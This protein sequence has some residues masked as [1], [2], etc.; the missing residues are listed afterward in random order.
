M[1]KNGGFPPIILCESKELEH[2]SDKSNLP[3]KERFFSNTS[4]NN[5]N[6]RQILVSK[7][8]TEPLIIIDEK[9]EDELEVID[10]I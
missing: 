7:Q 5:I 2:S 1:T 10:E 6:I 8:K 3:K 9:K 4:K